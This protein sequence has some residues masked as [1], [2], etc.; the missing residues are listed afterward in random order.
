MKTLE[1]QIYNYLREGH[2]PD[3]VANLV[4]DT[5]NKIEAEREL[6]KVTDEYLAVAVENINNYIKIATPDRTTITVDDLRSLLE[7][8]HITVKTLGDA[9]FED[10]LDKVFSRKFK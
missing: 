2:T 3:E 6:K 7:S 5:L 8:W 1:K 10:L 4:A 9:G